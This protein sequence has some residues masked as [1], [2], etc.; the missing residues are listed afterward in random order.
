MGA[1]EGRYGH[2]AGM[3][4]CIRLT[5][6]DFSGPPRLSH[7]Q[8]TLG[9]GGDPRDIVIAG[10]GSSV[11]GEFWGMHLLTWADFDSM[12]PPSGPPH[13]R[14]RKSTSNVNVLKVL[15]IRDK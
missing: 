5:T 1:L 8:R 3:G 10:G 7:I 13:L 14:T 12:I 2:Y 4:P 11:W 6:K 9:E 15:K